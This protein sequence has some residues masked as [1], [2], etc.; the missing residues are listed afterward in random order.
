MAMDHD[1]PK[2]TCWRREW[3]GD[4][5]DLGN[6]VHADYEE[7]LD[8]DGPW[9]PLYDQA[10]LDAA[11]AAERE[12]CAKL[13]EPKN[14]PEDWTEHARLMAACAARIREER[15][16]MHCWPWLEAAMRAGFAHYKGDGEWVFI[17]DAMRDMLTKF[18]VSVAETAE[19]EQREFCVTLCE[20][21]AERLRNSG[22][23]HEAAA[24]E[25]VADDLRASPRA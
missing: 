19:Q 6:Y 9:E 21:A 5:S 24:V 25:S 2:P 15:Q 1:Q 17:N 18:A 8:G 14:P 13:C 20:E 12:R 10:A 11:V 7:D 4:D 22:C 23:K 16:V 3:N